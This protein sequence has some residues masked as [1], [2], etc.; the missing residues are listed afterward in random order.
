MIDNSLAVP[1]Y[2]QIVQSV[3]GAIDRGELRQND[4][5]PS[6]NSIAEKFS[7]ARG[8]VFSAYNELRASGIIDSIPGKGY[9]ITSTQTKLTQTVCV[10]F[11]R[12][13]DA[14][15][16]I[17]DSLIGQLPKTCKVRTFFYNQNRDEFENIIREEAAYF[18]TYVIEPGIFKDTPAI[19]SALDPKQVLL[20][21]SGYKKFKKAFSGVYSNVE[22]ALSDSLTEHKQSALK[23]KRLFLVIPDQMPAKEIVAGFNRFGK[24]VNTPCEILHTIDGTTIRKGDA[25][26]VQ[27]N[28]Q[29]VELV[30]ATKAKGLQSGTDIGILSLS[31]CVLKSVIG[32]GITTLSPDYRAMGR[33]VA[34]LLLTNEQR[35]VENPFVY[36][37]RSSF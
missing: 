9:F 16:L 24:T 5:L 7:L 35:V 18:N 13:N 30:S 26:I 29:L 2:K 34:E 31:E 21:D 37:D 22:K 10:L 28:A 25:F 17:Y 23:Y 27:D 15:Q 33:T 11:S 20:L 12:F 19:L 4:T 14:S 6:V 32:E 3:C 8:S 36:T 1:I